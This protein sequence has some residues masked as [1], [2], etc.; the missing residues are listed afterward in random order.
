[1]SLHCRQ[2]PQGSFALSGELDIYNAQE[3]KNAMRDII[4]SHQTDVDLSEITEI[5]FVGIQVLL[6]AQREAATLNGGLRFQEPS[7]V[8]SEAFELLGVEAAFSLPPQ[9]GDVS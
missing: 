1:M 7:A 6:A 2:T 3:A 8:V 9:G 5:D 4:E